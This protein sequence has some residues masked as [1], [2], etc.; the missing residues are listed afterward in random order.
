MYSEFDDH[1]T[2]SYIYDV[3]MWDVHYRKESLKMPPSIL[4]DE[5][6]YFISRVGDQ[7][8]TAYIQ[9]YLGAANYT[10]DRAAY[11]MFKPEF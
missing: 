4:E 6:A 5:I 1:T 10:Y 7:M 8:D 2:D 3:A 11:D 9:G